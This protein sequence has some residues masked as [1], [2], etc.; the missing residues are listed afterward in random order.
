MA[1]DSVIKKEST[2]SI[3]G[4][5]TAHQNPETP[6]APTR[7]KRK[8]KLQI[9]ATKRRLA[10]LAGVCMIGVISSLTYWRLFIWQPAVV[11]PFTSA[12]SSSVSFPLYYPT[13]V[14]R[15][16]R[17]DTKSVTS[18]Q[19]GVIVFDLVG[20][21]NSKLYISEEARSSTFNLGGFYTSFQGLKEIGVSDGAIAVGRINDGQTEVASRANN[22]TWTLATTAANIPMDQLISMLKSLTHA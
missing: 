2:R 8:L 7:R 6:K 4:M 12:N 9:R 10:I 14:P 20:P 19:D 16:F 13:N 3:D 18:P 5:V 22:Q 21:K 17:I 11:D 15:G 1:S